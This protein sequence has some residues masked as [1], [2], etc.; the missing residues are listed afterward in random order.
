ML[1]RFKFWAIQT[2]IFLQCFSKCFFNIASRSTSPSH[3][4]YFVI[5]F[6]FIKRTP[7]KNGN[8]YRSLI[9]ENKTKIKQSQ[10]NFLHLQLCLPS[11]P[12]QFQQK[13]DKSYKAIQQLKMI[14]LCE[15]CKLKMPKN[16]YISLMCVFLYFTPALIQTKLLPTDS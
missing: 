14:S 5:K 13:A 16:Q 2:A 8:S 6:D 11:F 4:K 1:L 12:G 15:A 3:Q 9:C 10:H 7:L